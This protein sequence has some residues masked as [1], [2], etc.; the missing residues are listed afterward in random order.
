M[1][2]YILF[3]LDGTLTNPE[4]G[5]ITCVMYALEK[6]GI[7]VKD[8]KE[9]HPFIGPPLSYSFQTFY[10]LT[11]EESKQAILTYRERF[12]TKGLYENEVYPG[13]RELLEALKKRG[14]KIILATSKPE[15]FAIEI[16]KYFG[17]FQYFDFIAGATLD[18]QREEKTEV[19]TYALSQIAIEDKKQVIMVG[20]RNYDILGAKE[21]GIDSLGVLYGFGSREELEEAGAKILVE[22][23]EE[24]LDVIGE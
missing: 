19:I 4:I 9:L 2:Q 16:L 5:I 11:E 18:G 14:K 17:L 6:F 13:V 12:S 10:G 7:Y 15:P 22:R 24:I 3:D 21:N 20:D 1:Y 23:V 8:R